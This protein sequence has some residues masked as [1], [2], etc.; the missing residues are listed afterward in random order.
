M[1][2]N[3]YETLGVPQTA[4][5]EQLKSQY[6]MLIQQFHPDRLQNFPEWAKRETEETAKAINIAYDVL[7]DPAKRKEYDATLAGYVDTRPRPARRSRPEPRNSKVWGGKGGLDG[8]R[9][10]WFDKEFK[11]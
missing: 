4:S 1:W 6:R 10:F 7:S 5:P 11:K 8:L 9:K 3:H 2:A